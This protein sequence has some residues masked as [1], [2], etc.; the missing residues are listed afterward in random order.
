MYA[1]LNWIQIVLTVIQGK[2]LKK[3]PEA[4]N[5]CL[6]SVSINILH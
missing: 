6:S 5:I 4:D 1:P 3:E 2:E